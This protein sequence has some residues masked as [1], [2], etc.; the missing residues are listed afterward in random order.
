V[1]SHLSCCQDRNTLASSVAARQ[2]LPLSGIFVLMI[3]SLQ[4]HKVR[5][6]KI[7]KGESVRLEV[8][9]LNGADLVMELVR[10][11]CH[12]L[13]YNDLHNLLACDIHVCPFAQ[14][15]VPKPLILYQQV[16]SDKSRAS[17]ACIYLFSA[18]CKT[19]GMRTIFGFISVACMHGMQPPFFCH[20]TFVM[21]PCAGTCAQPAEATLAES[22]EQ[23]ARS[24][25]LPLRR[26]FFVV[27]EDRARSAGLSS[28]AGS[29][30]RH[31]AAP[32]DLRG[33]LISWV[34]FIFLPEAVNRC[35]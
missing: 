20:C 24:L 14:I 28:L 6:K 12:I 35:V 22:R 32:R 8:K 7:V 23:V 25:G 5:K 33:T 9:L 3:T 1:H 18:C 27:A 31:L 15:F 21:T 4:V 2:A 29:V 34:N 13:P 16:W 11:R 30:S 10:A 19:R 26:Q 17:C